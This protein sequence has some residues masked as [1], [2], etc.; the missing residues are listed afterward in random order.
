[1]APDSTSRSP[2]SLKNRSG[3]ISRSCDLNWSRWQAGLSAAASSA[4]LAHVCA[5]AGVPLLIPR[6]GC[7]DIV[8]FMLTWKPVN[9][10]L[11]PR[12]VGDAT[13]L[14]I[15]TVPLRQ[16]IGLFHEHFQP[17]SR[18]RISPYVEIEEF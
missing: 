10:G 8:G 1:M 4:L 7:Q 17:L 13:P 5:I 12:V 3:S 15:R 6:A 9:K 11:A 14:Q 16:A 2:S 18:I